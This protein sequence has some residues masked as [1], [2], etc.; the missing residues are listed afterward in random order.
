MGFDAEQAR[1][2][3]ESITGVGRHAGGRIPLS[4]GMEEVLQLAIEEARRLGHHYIGTEHLLLGLVRQGDGVGVDVLRRL[5]Y[6]PEQIRRQTS[7]ILQE[8]P[9]RRASRTVHLLPSLLK[10]VSEYNSYA[11]GLVLDT[12]DRL[13][14]DELSRRASPSHSSIFGLLKHIL[15]IEA[16][17]LARCQ[18]M[19]FELEIEGLGTIE[20]LRSAWEEL[21][22]RTHAFLS[23]IN[24]E[25][26][27]KDVSIERKQ[28]Q[29]VVP[30]WQVLLHIL[31]HSA[32]HRGELSIL[33]T[34]M[35][36]PLPELGS[37]GYFDGQTGQ[38][39]PGE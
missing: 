14:S 17:F 35:G 25:D 39:R 31:T 34:S 7:R 30:V 32:H 27:L 20:E 10:K 9:A 37:L 33:L 22:Q 16:L 1:E 28:P 13:D 6:T 23:S 2:E 18:D 8:S 36:R 3:V 29:R 11:N 12:V 24:P 21:D 4:P 15:E 38:S 5:G 26:L 19:Q